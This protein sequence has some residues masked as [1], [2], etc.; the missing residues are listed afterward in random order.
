MKTPVFL[1]A[2]LFGLTSSDALAQDANTSFFIT[3]MNPG[4]GA[5]LGGLEGADAHCTTL[6]EAAGLTGKTWRAYLSTSAVNARDR[7]GTGPWIGPNGEQVAQ[8]VAA[9]HGENDLSKATSLK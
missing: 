9:L 3:S 1:I 8:D 7:I 2:V 4:Q 6:A 5:N